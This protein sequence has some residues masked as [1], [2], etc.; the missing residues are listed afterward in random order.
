MKVLPKWQRD[1]RGL[2]LPAGN[3]VK[4]PPVKS[5]EVVM[6]EYETTNKGAAGGASSGLTAGQNQYGSDLDG[7]GIADLA[8]SID[9]IDGGFGNDEGG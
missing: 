5:H 1:A 2:R 3:T 7:G 4:E 8:T 6:D 9:G